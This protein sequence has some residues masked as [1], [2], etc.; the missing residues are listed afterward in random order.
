MS[1]WRESEKAG[2]GLEFA[3]TTNSFRIIR[4]AVRM[5]ITGELQYYSRVFRY[6]SRSWIWS[7]SS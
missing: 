2:R 1:G 6:D 7:G 3:A 4:M 5:S